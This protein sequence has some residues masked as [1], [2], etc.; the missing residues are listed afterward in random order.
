VFYK[1]SDDDREK[2]TSLD[3]PPPERGGLAARHHRRD[4]LL[5]RRAL[6]HQPLDRAA[7]RRGGARAADGLHRERAS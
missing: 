7:D 4:L 1:F 3:M 5:H 2:S 6:G